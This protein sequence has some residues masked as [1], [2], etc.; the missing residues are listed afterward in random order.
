MEKKEQN[1]DLRVSTV[2]A[3]SYRRRRRRR[4]AWFSTEMKISESSDKLQERDR[5]AD[6]KQEG[7]LLH[8]ATAFWSDE[9]RLL[10]W[11]FYACETMNWAQPKFEFN[12]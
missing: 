11:F 6:D 4:G 1:F 2:N 5:A 8:E 10:E 12:F 3:R 7:T 9:S